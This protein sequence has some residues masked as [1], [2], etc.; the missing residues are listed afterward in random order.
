MNMWQC[1]CCKGRVS[2]ADYARNIAGMKKCFFEGCDADP[3]D[4]VLV[5]VK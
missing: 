5:V 4:Y 2:V 1:P 3:R